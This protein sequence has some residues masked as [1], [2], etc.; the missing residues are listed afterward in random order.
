M[1]KARLNPKQK[2]WLKTFLL[3]HPYYKLERICEGL[4]NDR[5]LVLSGIET[6]PLALIREFVEAMPG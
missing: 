1:A 2:N 3:K 5:I 4:D 6:L